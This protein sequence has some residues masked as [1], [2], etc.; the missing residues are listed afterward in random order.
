LTIKNHI[1]ELEL[2]NRIK[3]FLNISNNLSITKPRLDRSNSNATVSLDITDIYILKK[4]IVPLYSKD[5]ILKTKKFKDFND[6]SFVVDIYFFGYHLVPP[7]P[8]L[9]GGGGNLLI[10]E[11]KNSWNNFRLSTHRLSRQTIKRIYLLILILRISLKL[12]FHYL[13]LMKLKTVLYL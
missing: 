2:F 5:G 7:P 8:S 13:L 10:T 6:W 4:S 1:K 11:I 9:K 12:Y 3:D